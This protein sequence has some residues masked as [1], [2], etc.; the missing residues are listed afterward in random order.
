[1]RSL[2]AFVFGIAL[3]FVSWTE[4]FAN[5]SF[6]LYLDQ[7]GSSV[8]MPDT[9]VMTQAFLI[10]E[11]ELEGGVH[12]F[13]LNLQGDPGILILSPTFP[14][15]AI[16]LGSSGDFVVGFGV[17]VPIVDGECLLATF[18]I[19]ATVS[20][21]CYITSSSSGNPSC[22]LLDGGLVW[23]MGNRYE[24]ECGAVLT[25]GAANCPE[26]AEPYGGGV[27]SAK[28]SFGAVKALYK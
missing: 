25:F 1:M 24:N 16:N 18:D 26:E 6:G 19:L 17:P 13:E 10:C 11:V 23:P 20:G 3:F 7:G 27:L 8:C 5:N 4:T 22:V 9:L 21:G 12:G 2:V 15:N 28:V 14:V